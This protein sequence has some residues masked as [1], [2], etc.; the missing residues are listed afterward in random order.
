MIY[1]VQQI[2]FDIY[3]YIKELE[4]EFEDWYIGISSNPKTKMQA[5]HNVNEAED[6]WLYR[7]ALS[8]RACQTIQRHFVEGL[9]LSGELVAEG[10]EDCNCIYLY[11]K[12]HRTCP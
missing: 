6:I 12:S 5:E 2:K 8:L 4:S 10:T 11:K 9:G 3:S 7:Q 1:S